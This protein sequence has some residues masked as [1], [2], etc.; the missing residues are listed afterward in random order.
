MSSRI[1]TFACLLKCSYFI[2][3]CGQGNR[4]YNWGSTYRNN[5]LDLRSEEVDFPLAVVHASIAG[6]LQDTN[7]SYCCGGSVY[8]MYRESVLLVHLGHAFKN[9]DVAIAAEIDV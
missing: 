9:G 5:L 6:R 4:L 8:G 1:A 7:V 3:R 2:A